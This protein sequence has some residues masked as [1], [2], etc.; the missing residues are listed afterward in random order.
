[1]T[2]DAKT[3]GEELLGAEIVAGKELTEAAGSVFD[4]LEKGSQLWRQQARWALED[5][6]SF[7]RSGL[8]KP[9]DPTPVIQLLERRSEHIASG[10]HD[11]GDLIEKECAPL[12]K[13]WTDFFSVVQQDWRQT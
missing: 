1:M 11:F 9:L 10:M 4:A 6:A 8:A 2:L 12:S 13:I 7:F 3:I 5:Y